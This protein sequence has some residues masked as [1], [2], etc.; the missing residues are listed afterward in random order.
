MPNVY[1][2]LAYIA[3][4][5]VTLQEV[6][7]CLI[8]A[9]GYCMP[10]VYCDLAHIATLIVTLQEAQDGGSDGEQDAVEDDS[11]QLDVSVLGS[12]DLS[13]HNCQSYLVLGG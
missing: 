2:D 8:C 5:I 13:H 6:I 11:Q 3:T 9:G 10:N 4:L 7:V 12:R 1:C